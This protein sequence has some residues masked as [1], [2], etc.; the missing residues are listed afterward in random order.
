MH[1]L[2]V[3]IVVDVQNCFMLSG[4]LSNPKAHME[5]MAEIDEIIRSKN[6]DVLVFS[7]DSHP[8]GHKSFGIY[9]PHCRDTSKEPCQGSSGSSGSLIPGYQT[10]IATGLTKSGISSSTVPVEIRNQ[11]IKGTDLSYLYNVF[12]TMRRVLDPNYVIHMDKSSGDDASDPAKSKR[13]IEYKKPCSGESDQ[14]IA[15][16]EK[17]EYCNFDAYSAFNYH[18][19]YDNNKEFDIG[20]H[21]NNSTGLLEFLLLGEVLRGKSKIQ[22]DVCGLVGNICVSNTTLHGCSLIRQV[23]NNPLCAS[24]V[25]FKNSPCSFKTIENV[26]AVTFNY[27][28]VRGTRFYAGAFG[29]PNAQMTTSS[30]DTKMVTEFI[31][32]CITSLNEINKTGKISEYLDVKQGIISINVP[33]THETSLTQ[34]G[35]E[36]QKS[37]YY[38]KYL[39][40]KNKYKQLNN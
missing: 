10:T 5:M 22:I 34:I 23:K 29:I 19:S 3:L 9:P 7:R 37:I 40:Y 15:H 39:K 1:E 32:K 13:V 17:G 6:Y 11:Y 20:T 14:I 24:N 26:D 27:N 38:Y 25:I 31:K 2:K 18:V 8:P 21:I 30:E 35:G 36:C 33:F 12:P 16:L 28:Y 4:S